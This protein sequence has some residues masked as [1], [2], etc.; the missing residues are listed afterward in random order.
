MNKTEVNLNKE[1]FE[2]EN[3]YQQALINDLTIQAQQYVNTN[4]YPTINLQV[5]NMLG[6][7]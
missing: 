7:V 1:D 4:C 5:Q 6:L 2:D 3:S